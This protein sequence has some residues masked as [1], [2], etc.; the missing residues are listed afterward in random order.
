MKTEIGS[1]YR[2]QLGPQYGFAA[3]MG[4]IDYLNRLGV[5][6]L[7]CSPITEAVTGSTHGY[8]GTDPTRVRD[9]LGGEE[10]FAQLARSLAQAGIGCVVDIVP[11]H[12]S[13]WAGGSW[14]R[15][16]LRDG[17][18]SELAEVFDVD[19]E[20]GAG[21]VVLPVLDRPLEEALA[22]GAVTIDVLGVEP[23]VVVGDVHLPL[24]GGV[25][26]PDEALSEVLANQHYRLVDWHDPSA[27]NYR[28]FFDIDG[29]VGIHT[30][31]REVFER[32]HALVGRL[33]ADGLVTGLRVDHVDGLAD[34]ARYLAW[35]RDLTGGA[36]VVVEKILTGDETLRRAWPVL[37]TTGYETLDDIGGALVDP[38]GYDTLVR[39]AEREGELR[40]STCASVCR[41]SVASTTFR[42]ELAR[43]ATSLGTSTGDLVDLTVALPV[44]RTYLD[45]GPVSSE[46]AEVLRRAT[47][48]IPGML[49]ILLD[50]AHAAAV[51]AWQ[52]RSGAVMAKGVEDTAWYRLAGHLAFCE[53]GGEPARPRTGSV[54]RLHER[55][56]ERAASR[57]TGLVPGT[58]HDTKRT[59]DVRA[60]LYAL[61]ELATSFE[62]GLER[63]RELL[64]VATAPAGRPGH[65]TGV[66]HGTGVAVE[67]G[68]AHARSLADSRLLAET[69]LAMLPASGETVETD[70]ELAGRI[71]RA[72]VKGAREAGVVTTWDHPDDTAE[73]EVEKIVE[74]SLAQ[75][76]AIV[77]EA[78]GELVGEVARLGATL[79]LSSVL[80]RSVL[81]GSPDCYQGDEAWNLA[82]VDPDNRRP[83][84]FASLAARLAALGPAAIVGA[85]PVGAPPRGS[86]ATDSAEVARRC[87]TTWQT[88]DVKLLVTATTLAARRRAP[89]AFGR[90]AAYRGVTVVGPASGSVVA[91]ARAATGVGPWAIGVATRLPA[92]LRAEAADLPAGEGSYGA[93]EIV[94]PPGAGR[95]FVEMCSGTSVEASGSRIAIAETCAHLP[96]GLLL[97]A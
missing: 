75:R 7:Y 49:E 93:T 23:T 64:G 76:A 37:G 13:T 25:P 35:L 56:A 14:W 44:Y 19:W 90:D 21:K 9:E 81:P 15:T 46:D 51:A 2:V 16:L 52:Q 42:E 17:Q 72:L 20:K 58:T 77:H 18:E 78:F 38:D 8:D 26:R 67:P 92:R 95:H 91:C 66:E 10:G 45:G 55:A 60:R 71:R 69:V 82:L 6:S 96:V 97:P 4:C 1:T 57:S 48:G 80:L 36:P 47:A 62:D 86:D 89:E 94:L 85:S 70:Q 24:S 32:T 53:V 27:R 30:E 41:R 22:R 40:V 31:R 68:S 28:R 11:N 74:R 87:R 54:D 43:I 84:D 50:P 33:V 3:A 61:S 39:A 12:L 73:H 63:F 88:G 5:E 65:G 34:P 83:V 59:A 79:S 29:L